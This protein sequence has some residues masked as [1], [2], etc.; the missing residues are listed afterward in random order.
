MGGAVDRG[1][2]GSKSQSGWGLGRDRGA[3]LARG[4]AGGLCGNSSR[5]IPR[6]LSSRTPKANTSF[7]FFFFSPTSQPL[8]R[9]F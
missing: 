2:L 1:V 7:F 6:V 9:S 8:P 4:L 3:G 5:E